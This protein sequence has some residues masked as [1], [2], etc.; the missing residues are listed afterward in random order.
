ME[1]VW[2]GW[3]DW[4]DHDSFFGSA[5]VFTPDLFP[6]PPGFNIYATIALSYYRIVDDVVAQRRGGLANASIMRWT[7]HNPDGTTTTDSPV[8]SLQRSLLIDNCASITFTLF[9]AGG[10]GSA[11]ISIFRR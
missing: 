10:E 4:S 9:V 7:V 11:P 8:G 5:A 6:L 1:I 3:I 2:N